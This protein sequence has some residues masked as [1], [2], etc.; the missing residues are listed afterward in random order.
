MEVDSI[1]NRSSVFN[2]AHQLT[3]FSDWTSYCHSCETAN[4][5]DVVAVK[6]RT[7]LPCWKR[8]T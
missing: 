5:E 1:H 3:T 7:T 8:C 4:T 6:K 2:Y